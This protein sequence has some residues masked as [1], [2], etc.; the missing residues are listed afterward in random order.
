MQL[1]LYEQ[2]Y[3]NNKAQIDQKLRTISEQAQAEAE[4]KWKMFLVE[5]LLNLVKSCIIRG[6]LII[7]VNLN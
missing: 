7:K 5:I 3:K 4:K 2:L 6:T 1:F